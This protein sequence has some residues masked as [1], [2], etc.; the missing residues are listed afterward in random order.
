MKMPSVKAAFFFDLY[1]NFI[2]EEANYCAFLRVD[3]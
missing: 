2:T 1:G 3:L